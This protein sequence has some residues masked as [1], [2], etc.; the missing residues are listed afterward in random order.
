MSPEERQAEEQAE[1]RKKRVAANENFHEQLVRK[2]NDFRFRALFIAVATARAAF[3]ATAA[4]DTAIASTLEERAAGPRAEKLGAEAQE[5][6]G[7]GAGAGA[8]GADLPETLQ[9][10]APRKMSLRYGENPHQRAA[11]Y[12]DGSRRGIANA[13][14][15]P[16]LR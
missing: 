2:L 1:S 14:G 12:T 4:Y 15:S 13:C 9:I 6:P 10:A 11:L 8:Q 16:S 7:S 5:A 3:A